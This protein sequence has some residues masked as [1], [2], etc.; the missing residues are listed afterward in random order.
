MTPVPT[1]AFA[2]L[3]CKTNQAETVRLLGQLQQDLAVVP[4]EQGAD[5][6]V[7]NTCTVT[8]EAD[9]QSRQL[10]RRAHRANPDAAICL[11]CIKQA[12]KAFDRDPDVDWKWNS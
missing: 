12:A 9:R 10:I 6:Y 2:T 5:I 8:H 4:F 7:I 1:I 3:G 11:D